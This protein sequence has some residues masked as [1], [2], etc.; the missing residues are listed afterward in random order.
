MPVDYDPG[1]FGQDRDRDLERRLLVVTLLAFVVI[2]SWNGIMQR[3]YPAPARPLATPPSASVGA[4]DATPPAETAELPPA[5]VPTAAPAPA[6]PASYEA[7]AESEARTAVVTT[8]LL[9]ATFTNAGGRL[10]SLKLREF[11]EDLPEDGK[12]PRRLE[13]IPRQMIDKDLLP[14]ALEIPGEA[15]LTKSLNAALF[16]VEPQRLELADGEEGT[17]T[18]R[19]RMPDGLEVEKRV[20]FRGGSYL[21][22]VDATVRRLPTVAS[23]EPRAIPAR[24]LWGPGFSNPS[25]SHLAREGSHSSY[26]YFGRAI[27]HSSG[28]VYRKA[29]TEVKTAADVPGAVSFAGLE[30]RY[31]AVIFLPKGAPLEVAYRPYV[32]EAEGK[33]RQ[34]LELSVALPTGGAASGFDLFVGPKSYDILRATHPA[35]V[36]VIDFGNYLGP[37]VKL[38]LLGLHRIHAI[39]RNYGLAIIAL[40]LLIRFALLP[41]TLKS[42]KQMKRMQLLQPK[43]NAIR[44]RY[45]R[46]PSDPEERREAK[47]R[48]NEETMALYKK[49]GVNPVGGCFPMLLQMPFLFAFYGVLTVAIELRHEPFLWWIHDLSDKDPLYITPVLM[50]LAQYVSQR[51]TPVA[52]ADPVQQRMMNIMPLFF[53]WIFVNV[54][55]GLVIYWLTSNL[56]QIGQQVVLKRLEAPPATVPGT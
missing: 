50:T 9:E 39:T 22:T 24:L 16:T 56:F 25:P 18:F 3:L 20:T 7:L 8:G 42:Y 53:L 30:E 41:L 14:L 29:K 1:S 12:T 37:L 31:F 54:P 51:L 38:M 36:D 23:A 49:E 11:A 2:L 55:S 33:E 4:K 10:R 15:A 47:M 5:T 46:L 19:L 27:Y 35:L 26:E 34:E 6:A 52:A 44:D 28:R 40:T 43:V 32:F 17:V 21:L 48:M 45:K 13:T